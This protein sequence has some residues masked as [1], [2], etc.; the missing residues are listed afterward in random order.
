MIIK[1]WEKQHGVASQSP[2]PAPS[3]MGKSKAGVTEDG[4]LSILDDLGLTNSQSNEDGM[5]P[6]FDNGKEAIVYPEPFILNDRD[7]LSDYMDEPEDPNS[8]FYYLLEVVKPT[9]SEEDII[10]PVIQV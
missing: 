4:I 5:L 10:P 3:I 2:K 6:E 7:N 8:V 1:L 9:G